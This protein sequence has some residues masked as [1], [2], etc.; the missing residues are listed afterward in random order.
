MATFKQ[1]I[2]RFLYPLIRKASKSGKNGTVIS[3]ENNASSIVSFY[4]QKAILNN[5]NPI[6]FSVYSGKKVLIVNTASNCGYTGQ[7]AEL[8]KLHE[9]LGDKLAIIAFPANDFAE[10]EKSSDNEISQFCQINYG[11]TFPIAKKGVVVK[12]K[13]QQPIFKWLTDSRANGW[14]SHQ[15]D[16][17]FSK[18]VIDEKG[19]LT[20]YF[21][22]SISPLDSEFLKAVE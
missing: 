1:K 7:Y 6:D 14:N 17:N 12:S 10:Q 9:K 8:Q 3:N 5:G 18:Y 11:V 13:E 4:Q 16:W 21:G 22:P 19:N 2:L 15:P 20:N